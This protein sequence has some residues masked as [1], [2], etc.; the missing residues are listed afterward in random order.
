[1][2]YAKKDGVFTERGIR[3]QQGVRTDLELVKDRIEAGAT[4]TDIAFDFPIHFIKF[5]TGIVK[6][7]MYRNIKL[8]RLILFRPITVTVLVGAAGSGKTYWDCTQRAEGGL[9][10]VPRKQG[11]KLWFD[12]YE[13]EK[14]FLFD[15]FTGSLCSH[16]ENPEVP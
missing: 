7:I 9:Y 12:G 16:E 15:N 6:L 4:A 11:D 2:D 8:D 13:G 10:I 1:M 5:G 14:N 3:N